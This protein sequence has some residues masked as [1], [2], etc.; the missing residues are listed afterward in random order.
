MNKMNRDEVKR[1]H[2]AQYKSERIMDLWKKRE[3]KEAAA[4]FRRMIGIEREDE[5]IDEKGIDREASDST[6]VHSGREDAGTV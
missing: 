6:V 5:D 4:H 1:Y 2:E 3:E